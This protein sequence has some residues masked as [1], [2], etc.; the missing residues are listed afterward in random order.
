MTSALSIR[1]AVPADAPAL[2][3]L[4]ARMDAE[5]HPDRPALAALARACEAF[6][7]RELGQERFRAWLAL[8]REHVV[9]SALLHVFDTLPRSGVAVAR[10]GRVRN[11]FVEPA[12]R[13]RG[14]ASELMRELIAEARRL[15]IDRLT[16]GASA[17]GKALYET[18]GFVV[19]TNEMIWT[20]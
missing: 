15:Q 10:D 4:R 18:L 17:Q 11:V 2:A 13:R 8:D 19:R 16:L 14:V 5:M 6:F 9:G 20:P 7:G 12:Y 1:R 3:A